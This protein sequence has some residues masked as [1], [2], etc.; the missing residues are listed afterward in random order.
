MV[1]LNLRAGSLRKIPSKTTQNEKQEKLS[2]HSQST[3]QTNVAQIFVSEI[4]LNIKI[5]IYFFSTQQLTL[6]LATQGWFMELKYYYGTRS[7][8]DIFEY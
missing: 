6:L 5:E 2:P 3:I 7:D 8:G 1:T 4:F